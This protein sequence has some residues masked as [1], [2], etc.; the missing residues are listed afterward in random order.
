MWESKQTEE[1][2]KQKRGEEEE[3]KKNKKESNTER[4]R[5]KS[6]NSFIKKLN[7]YVFREFQPHL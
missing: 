7:A 1:K 6:M 4:N 2:T 5:L 3:L